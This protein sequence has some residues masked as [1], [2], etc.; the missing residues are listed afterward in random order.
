MRLSP[1]LLAAFTV[2]AT[3]GFSS[4]AK[5]ETIPRPLEINPPSTK[6]IPTKPSKKPALR[7]RLGTAQTVDASPTPQSPE[8][9]PRNPQSKRVSLGEPATSSS[10]A[11]IQ[12]GEL[13]ETNSKDP[14]VSDPEAAALEDKPQVSSVSRQNEFLALLAGIEERREVSPSLLARIK[15]A[16]RQEGDSALFAQVDAEVGQDADRSR[17]AQ[18]GNDETADEPEGESTAEPAPAEE[19]AEPATEAEQSTQDA[20]VLVAEVDVQSV[21]GD[22]PPEL[23]DE[24]YEVI[25]TRPGRTTTRSQLQEDINNIFATGFFANVRAIPEDTPLGV[26]ITFR[27]QPNPVLTGVRIS[28][29]EVLPQTTVDEIFQEQYGEIINLVEFQESILELNQWYQDNGYV[30]AQVIAAP[31]ISPSGI[32]TLVVAEGVIEDIDVRF[33]SQDGETEDEEGNPIRGRTRDFIITREFESKPGDVFNQSEIERDLQ[34]VFGLGIFEDVRLSLAPGEDDPLKVRVV[35]NVTERNTGSVAAGVGFNFRGDI[36]GTVSYRQDNFGGNNQKLSAEIQ[37]STS[38]LL[39]DLSFTD[40]WIAGD[41]YRTSYTVNAFARQSTSLV[42]DNGPTEVKLANGDDVRLRR[43]G[44]GVSFTR[45]LDNGWRGSLG[46]QYQRVVTVDEGGDRVTE[47]ALGNPLSFSGSGRDDLWTFQLGFVRDRRNNPLSPTRGSL[48]RLAT[49]QSVPLGSGSILMNRLRTSYSQYIPVDLTGF[50]DG[51]EAFAFNVQAGT[52]IGDLP[53]YEAFS[54]GGGN[55]VR[56][57]EEGGLAASRSFVQATAE[58]RF[59][60]FASF[61]GGALFVDF[62]SALG[63]QGDVLGDPGLVRDKPG[64]G[65]GYGPGLRVQTPLGPLRVDFGFSDDGGNRIHFGLGERF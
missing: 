15:I 5:G 56:G 43:F 9:I 27:V 17:L 53:P 13:A 38:D 10:P 42:F 52:V 35:V 8:Q 57:F 2:S 39:F 65:F 34:Q 55:S 51:P 45:P 49:E 28:G 37:L 33:I 6:F 60:L 61:L 11:K 58:Y 30:L 59:P 40:P 20:R 7:A 22:L 47:D 21:S 3:L 14:A 36:F 62:G 54:L 48:L 16:G 50:G 44:G 19:A 24:V 63:T 41:P 32:A 46:T 4:Q 64:S 31:Q 29:N 25:Q 12:A 1:V 23:E 18:T 26:R